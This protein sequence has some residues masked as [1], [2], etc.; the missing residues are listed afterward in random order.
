[1]LSN[2][3]G[4]LDI[5]ANEEQNSMAEGDIKNNI[6]LD[7]RSSINIFSNPQLVMDIKISNQ[8]IHLS[9]NVG[10]KINQTQAMIP[11]YG[12]L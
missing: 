5:K 4:D 11:D 8:V 1:M 3:V 7:N 6:I 9:T 2:I 12:K 10:S